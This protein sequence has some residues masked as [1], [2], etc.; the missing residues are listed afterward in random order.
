MKKQGIKPNL[1]QF[2]SSKIKTQK[3]PSHNIKKIPSSNIPYN[4]TKQLNPNTNSNKNTE[5]LSLLNSLKGKDPKKLVKLEVNN[6]LN[7][8]K[9]SNY[10][11]NNNNNCLNK[12]IQN[13]CNNL[14]KSKTTDKIAE[15]KINLLIGYQ[16][17]Q[18]NINNKKIMIKQNNIKKLNKY[19]LNIVKIPKYDNSSFKQAMK[20]YTLK[21]E[22]KTIQIEELSSYF[23]PMRNIL[24]FSNANKGK[25][26][27]NINSSINIHK[28][29]KNDEKHKNGENILNDKDLG[30]LNIN[31]DNTNEKILNNN[32]I[33][34]DDD[35]IENFQS[36]TN[37]INNKVLND[38]DNND[39]NNNNSNECNKNN[40]INNI[41][42][43]LI[44]NCV[45]N[46]KNISFSQRNNKTTSIPFSIKIDNTNTMG[47]DNN[48]TSIY[49]IENTNT[50]S[51]TNN[52]INSKNVSENETQISTNYNININNGNQDTKTTQSQTQT[53]SSQTLYQFRP[54]KIHL[55]K[56]GINL[57]AMHF[58]NQILQ[59]ILNKRKQNK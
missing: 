27:N 28:Y 1:R 10:N 29:F 37:L 58:K 44:K 36:D 23:R 34:Y 57:S 4:F 8:A 21:S 20:Y 50:N 24:G 47:N 26:H 19:S 6:N 18:A 54:R 42:T 14:R 51:N 40:I 16:E 9:I 17:N 25:S 45:F 55:P 52:I 32:S 15:N 35:K 49:N 7:D 5:K 53:Q 11:F 48:K 39:N 46:N 59:N 33:G 22:S 2:L 31:I 3:K 38:L 43:S 12:E 30:N 13:D 56:N 41:N